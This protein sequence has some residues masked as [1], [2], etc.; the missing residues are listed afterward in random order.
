MDNIQNLLG[1]GIDFQ[2]RGDLSSA[3]KIYREILNLDHRHF[4]A[5]YLSS[6]IAVSQSELNE[7]KNLLLQALETLPRHIE[8]NFN[9]AVISE[10]LNEH[11]NALDHYDKLISIS[12]DH[13]QGIFNRASL[14]AKLGNIDDAY[15]D[16]KR[17]VEIKPDFAAARSNFEKLKSKIE[18]NEDIAG[19]DLTLF[20]Q[21][22]EKGLWL[23]ENGQ[24]D[25]ALKSFTQ[26]LK[27]DPNSQ[28]ALH[29]LGMTLEKMG[30]LAKARECYEQVLAF[31]PTLAQTH[32]NLGNVLRELNQVEDAVHHFECA[33]KINPNYSEALSNL[34]WT[35]YRMHQ[36]EKAITCYKRALELN[37][38]LSAARFNLSLCQL[39]IGN[40]ENGWAN[41]ESRMD[42]PSYK[43]KILN[44]PQW[45]GQASLE[46]KVIYIHSEQGLGDTIQFCRYVPLLAKLGAT[47]IF[48]PQA[49]L[50][51]LLKNLHG[52]SEI[53][54]ARKPTP[55]H[56]FHCPLMSLPLAFK[57][58]LATIPNAI[59]YI[60]VD[61]LKQKYWLQKLSHIVKPKIG[62]VWSGGF[63]P[64]QPEIWEVNKRRNIELSQI[65]KLQ[66]KDFH[67][68]SLQKGAEAESELIDK[69]AQL[70][71]D[72]NFSNF[73][74]E[75]NDFT[76]TAA[77]ISTLDL[78]ISVDTS[79]AHLA[80]AIGKPTWILNRYDSCWRWSN[81]DVET[82]WYPSVKLYRQKRD[83]DWNTVIEEVRQELQKTFF[84]E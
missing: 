74:D 46:G 77:L 76:D 17:V 68:V 53:V 55:H 33:I 62:L 83:G 52:L 37:P 2:R 24:L 45:D 78:V 84:N 35:L 60:D 48:E 7:A 18:G 36:F 39:S 82:A 22:H 47:V 6:S 28:E 42:Q 73:S 4:D 63:R 31:N 72:E 38:K 30:G 9:L 8:A 54:T 66:D 3:K 75:L 5:L 27:I 49:P 58:T 12:P 56:D 41:Y 13:I 19:N 23:Y 81:K 43:K 15:K 70:W 67:F 20:T 34:G 71:T 1:K 51:S 64:N 40:F 80:G 26:A 61:I 69:Q 50:V 16:L 65:S 14:H 44:C 57:T 21:L 11:Q 10:K 29:N 25:E 79:T 32:N 59:P